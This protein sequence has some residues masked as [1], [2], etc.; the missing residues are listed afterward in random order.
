MQTLPRNLRLACVCHDH[1]SFVH[2][3]SPGR[4]FGNAPCLART[5]LITSK[6]S[7]SCTTPR[8]CL[9]ATVTCWF[10]ASLSTKFLRSFSTGAPEHNL[11]FDRIITARLAT[12]RQS[13]SFERQKALASRRGFSLSVWNSWYRSPDTTHCAFSR[14]RPEH[15][16]L[17]L[18]NDLHGGRQPGHWPLRRRESGFRALKCPYCRQSSQ[19]GRVRSSLDE[20]GR[21]QQEAVGA[22]LFGSQ[23]N[24]MAV[25]VP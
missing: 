1:R 17:P 10:N 18:T 16:C 23:A 3:V 8:T 15:L 20:V 2:L 14:T 6:S 24:W 21:E 5:D 22:G 19:S 13:G 7:L 9:S 12:D 11:S 4:R 25:W